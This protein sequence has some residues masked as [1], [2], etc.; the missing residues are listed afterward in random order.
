M[1]ALAKL[2]ERLNM[3]QEQLEEQ[4]KA[5]AELDKW[6]EKLEKESMYLY[7]SP[8]GYI[9]KIIRIQLYRLSIL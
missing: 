2:E 5:Y 9:N 1:E 3:Q 7:T 8:L 4:R 6:K